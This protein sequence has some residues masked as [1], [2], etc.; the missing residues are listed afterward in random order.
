MP[1]H[2]TTPE[3]LAVADDLEAQLEQSPPSI[4]AVVG[5]AAGGELGLAD[6]H[7]RDSLIDALLCGE[8]P[9]PILVHNERATVDERAVALGALA[10]S[11]GDEI[12][13]HIVGF[14]DT[15]E[16]FA[17]V[18]EQFRELP[19]EISSVP[20]LITEICD[21]LVRIAAIGRELSTGGAQAGR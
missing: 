4:A 8:D 2:A 18:I 9:R 1:Q 7:V 14:I 6:R 21:R 3:E 10:R 19:D 5:P 12:G 13:N 20:G 16:R 15:T 11:A 17:L